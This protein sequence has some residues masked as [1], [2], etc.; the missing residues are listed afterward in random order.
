[1]MKE[2]DLNLIKE[3]RKNSR[4]SLTRISRKTKIPIS[5]I[6]DKLKFY[7]KKLIIKHTALI[8]FKQLGFDIRVRLLLAA[9]QKDALKNYLLYHERINSV[10]RINNG[11]D[12]EIEALFRN[13]AE[14]KNFLEDIEQFGII[15]IK[16]YFILDDLLREGFMTAEAY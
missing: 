10:F 1:M 11:F 6:Y 2:K 14:F 8:D 16:E 15:E 5:T 12:Y 13:M 4:Q 7:E 9:K 3:F